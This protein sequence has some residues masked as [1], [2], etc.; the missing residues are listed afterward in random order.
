MARGATN[1]RNVCYDTYPEG[2]VVVYVS[3]PQEGSQ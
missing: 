3:Q 1:W 2:L